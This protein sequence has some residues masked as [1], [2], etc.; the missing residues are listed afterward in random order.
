MSRF[1]LQN[2]FIKVYIIQFL[3]NIS[4][5]IRSQSYALETCVAVLIVNLFE[6]GRE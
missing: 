1:V 4:I 5:E 6:Y 2:N 3:I